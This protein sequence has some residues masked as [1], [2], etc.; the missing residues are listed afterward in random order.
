MGISLLLGMLVGLQ[1][2]RAGTGVAGV[3]TFAL[4]TVV[5]TLAAILA[6]RYGAWVLAAALVG[7]VAAA[8]MGNVTLIRQGRLDP[9]TTTEMAMLVM[10]LTGAMVWTGPREVAAAVG[11]ATAIVLQAKVRLHRFVAAL[12]ERDWRAILQFALVTLIILPVV[13]NEAYG[14]YGVLNPWQIWLMVVLVV[15]IS[16]AGYVAYRAL[17]AEGALLASGLIGGLISSTAT[18]VSY[19]QRSRAGGMGSAAVMAI[20]LASCVAIIRVLVEIRVVAP[21]LVMHAAGPLLV[22]FVVGAVLA[23]GLWWRVRRARTELP[24]QTNPTELRSALIFAAV[25]A[26]VLLVVAAAR[27]RL[28]E[29]G[30]YVVGFLSGLV[31]MDAITL[32]TSRLVDEGRL[33]VETG[34][35]TIVLALVGNLIFKM[36][37]VGWLGSR[38]V[39]AE[40]AVVLGTMAASAAVVLVAWP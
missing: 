3:R 35:R 39:G 2:Q 29:G 34:W 23:A 22:V 24:E 30:V 20:L 28:G 4:I 40:V 18:T 11:A 19:A 37:L 38:A 36:G 25:Y 7:V 9:G 27:E 31:N 1:R 13:P 17:G 15:G 21:E 32:S 12:G 26:L 5:G 16:L 33:G 14:P 8:A 10:F 6:D